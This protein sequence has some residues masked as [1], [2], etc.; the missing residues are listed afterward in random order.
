MPT[1]KLVLGEFLCARRARLS[2][3]DVGLMATPGRR[4]KGLRREEVAERAG[5]SLEYYVRLEQGRSHQ[6]SHQVLAALAQALNLD[7]VSREYMYRL[8]HP[9]PAEAA[10]TSAPEVSRVILRLMEQWEHTPAYVFDRHQDILVVNA[11][12]VALSPEYIVPGNN[13]VLLLFSAIEEQRT[14]SDWR[15][16]ARAVVAAL[17]CYGDPTSPRMQQIVG[18]LSTRDQDFREMWAEHEVAPFQ[19][20]TAPN[21]V[22]GFGWV[23]LP[24]Q[25]FE[26]PGGYFLDVKLV[27]P[28]TRAAAAVE[29]LAASVG[30]QA[31]GSSGSVS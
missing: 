13:L 29:F 7:D 28:N 25:I 4:V 9:S 23:D 8:A 10:P 1:A 17:R 2:P 19:S 11:L 31:T 3:T 30:A 6:I 16:T 12:A 18:E 22:P 26:V 27:E 24:W 20:G 5:I 15:N 14:N 21:L